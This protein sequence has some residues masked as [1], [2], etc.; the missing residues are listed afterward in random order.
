MKK[1]V[2]MILVAL[3]GLVFSAGL[4]SYP[5]D[6]YDQTGIRRL[7]HLQM[8]NNEALA[9]KKSIEGALKSLDAIALHLTETT[10]DS[11]L[12]KVDIDRELQ[13]KVDRLFPNM[14]ESYSLSLL[15]ITPGRPLRYASKQDK[16]EY[17][18]GSVGK[19]AVAI[20]LFSELE[21]IYPDSFD[22]RQQLLR[23]KYVVGGQWVLTDEHTIPVFDV[24]TKKIVK[25]IA[26]ATDNFTLYEW[27][28]HMMSVSNNGAASV[29]W[30]EALLMRVFG[31]AYPSLTN[32][33]ANDY[34]TTTPKAELSTL[35]MQV[36]NEPLRQI[37]ITENE[38]RLGKFFTRGAGNII[39]GGG[40]STG[41]TRGLM[42]FMVALEQ[43]EVVDPASSLE[44][45]RLMYMTDRRIRYAASTALSKA[46][47][48][49]KSGSLYSC[50]AEDGY[51]CEKY[52]GNKANYMNSVAIVEHPDSTIYMVCLMSNVLK[53]NSS[54]DHFAL[55]SSIDKLLH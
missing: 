6:G 53:K 9:G 2:L 26:Q 30:R 47:V 45:K 31:E 40:G 36:V 5:I 28:D 49:F 8:V 1:L 4:S 29:I 48:Y 16:R 17:Q 3:F 38:W 24:D 14:H 46:A 41:T 50:A 18:P 51:T 35:A 19:L 23:D 7:L 54:G 15:D 27:V 33:Q 37:D 21:S 12:S 52:K 42:K 20:A 13:R 39:P 44:I 10:S 34:F 25:R 55:A 11:L 22:E 43:G 32:E